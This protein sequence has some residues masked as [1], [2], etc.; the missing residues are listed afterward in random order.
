M[1]FL[2]FFRA[3]NKQHKSGHKPAIPV[4]APGKPLPLKSVSVL[5]LCVLLFGVCCF[6]ASYLSHSHSNKGAALPEWRAAS[7]RVI[8]AAPQFNPQTDDS[9]H[10][11]SHNASTDENKSI[12]KRLNSQS[13]VFEA[14][15]LP[16]S[17]SL[18]HTA[19]LVTNL[20]VGHV[21]LLEGEMVKATLETAINSDFAGLVR[22]IVAEPV[23]CF[24]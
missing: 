5:I 2:S 3:T 13:R 7:R 19:K 6:V 23:Y 24:M 10:A 22:A 17:L 14:A 16:Q 11:D 9:K 20:Q 15:V 8:A 12:T 1:S 21:Y 18:Q 4:L